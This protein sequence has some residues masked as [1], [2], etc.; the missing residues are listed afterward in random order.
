MTAA[1]PT[2]RRLGSISSSHATSRGS[3]RRVWFATV[4]RAKSTGKRF[5]V[6]ARRSAGEGYGT[7]DELE[8]AGANQL[9]DFPADLARA[10][11]SMGD[12]KQFAG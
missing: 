2:A 4:G 9:V 5:A 11:L 7:R 12:G 10:V 8:A 3:L 6:M 1:F